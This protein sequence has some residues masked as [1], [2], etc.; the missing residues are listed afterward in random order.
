MHRTIKGRS[1]WNYYLISLDSYRVVSKNLSRKG[2]DGNSYRNRDEDNLLHVSIKSP[3][4]CTTIAESRVCYYLAWMN[5]NFNSWSWNYFTVL[6]EKFILFCGIHN[7]NLWISV[8]K[9]V[10]W[11]GFSRVEWTIAVLNLFRTHL[12]LNSFST[13][14]M[15]VTHTWRKEN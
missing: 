1:I 15:V 11:R 9:S 14:V 3:V 5:K 13:S 7:R 10:H 8:L 12:S 2:P 6:A 4:R